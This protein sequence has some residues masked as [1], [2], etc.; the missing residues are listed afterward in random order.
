MILKKV[1]MIPKMIPKK[2]KMIP[3]N[4]LLTMYQTCLSTNNENKTEI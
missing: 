3:K 4:D 2:V 1:K